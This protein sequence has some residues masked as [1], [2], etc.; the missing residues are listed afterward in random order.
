MFQKF[1]RFLSLT[2]CALLLL[3]MLPQAPLWTTAEAIQGTCGDNVSWSL[4]DGTL[5]IS[6]SGLMHN[7][8]LDSYLNS[9]LYSTAPWIGYRSQITRVVVQYGVT[10]IGN[11]SFY[12][13]TSLTDVTIPDSVTSIGSYA[14][15]KCTGLKSITIPD[16]VTGIG[17]YAFCGCENLKS[18]H[19]TDMAAWCRILFDGSNTNPLS[20]GAGLYLNGILVTNLIIPDGVPCIGKYAFDGY[21]SLTTATIGNSVTHIGNYAFG[22]C[23]SLTTATIGNSVTHI[24]G[25]AFSYCDSLTDV[26]IGDN[27]THIG[28]YAFGGCDS[29]T[30]VTI[31]NSVTHIGEYAF[32]WCTSLSD[33]TIPDSVTSIGD[34]AFYS[35][36][37]LTDITFL[38]ESPSIADC[39][40]RNVYA[41]A[42]YPCNK[43]TWTTSARQKYGINFTWEMFHTLDVIVN[44]Q[45]ATC[46]NDAIATGLCRN[47]SGITTKPIP[48]TAL[49]HCYEENGLCSRCG[50]APE[51]TI[52][53]TDTYGDG[54]NKAAIQ[55]YANNK[56][57]DT[58]TISSTYGVSGLRKEVTIDYTPGKIYTF[59]WVSGSYDVQCRFTITMDGEVL[60]T[61]SGAPDKEIFYTICDHRYENVIT[62]PNCTQEGY[63]TKTCT[64]CGDS[65]VIDPIPATGH[66]YGSEVVAPT[67]TED[68][69][70]LYTCSVC[71]NTET[72]SIP[73]TALGHEYEDGRCLYC[74]SMCEHHY[75]NG[76][77]TTCGEAEPPIG[78]TL[79]GTMLLPCENVKVQLFVDGE[80]APP[81]TAQIDGEQY[82]FTGVTPGAYLLKVSC[83]GGVPRAYPVTLIPGENTQN[84]TLCRPGDVSGDRELTVLDVA[85]LYAHVRGTATLDGYALQC[86]D[87]SG[88]GEVT[89]VD[90]AI[91]YRQT[92]A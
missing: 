6:G 36:T 65:A 71:G 3:A 41:T 81:Y 49:G 79:T 24:G 12:D 63:T 5:T 39:S 83:D 48:G 82:R 29:L 42:Y 27:V 50:K 55:V 59:Q 16:S 7:Y 60:Y 61:C 45:D 14:F 2:L 11:F 54:W 84:V 70:T 46:V 23:I 28:D 91:A 33:I 64:I 9:S 75:E 18:V 10:G 77:C 56:L 57:V 69:Y 87:L 31:G 20:N 68:G 62:P 43:T 44:T 32:T 17:S 58:L 90:T 51:V 92:K 19:I 30:S 76:T 1:R 37:G 85:M 80:D 47:C 26:T 72:V 89:I 88:D 8:T 13:C 35:C 67:C 15:Y 86:A 53:M 34:Y 74:S 22:D 40:F 25:N 4:E 73:G 52:S 21:T 38:G 66:S 78:A